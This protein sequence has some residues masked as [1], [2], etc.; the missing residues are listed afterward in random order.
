MVQFGVLLALAGTGW[1]L[2]SAAFITLLA[3]APVLTP[4]DFVHHVVLAPQVGL[5]EAWLALGALGAAPVFCVSV[6]AMPLLLERRDR[7]ASRADEAGK[8]CWPIRWH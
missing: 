6:V 4:M 1:V 5:F 3:A 2:T 7:A 8:L